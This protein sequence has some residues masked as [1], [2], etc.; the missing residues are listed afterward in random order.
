MSKESLNAVVTQRIEMS[1]ELV[2]FRVAPDG[3]ELP[4]FEAGQFAVLGL[5]GKS[6]R[7]IW[8]DPEEKPPEP[9]RLI[10]RAYSLASSSASSEYLEFYIMIVRSG[11]LTPRL[12]SLEQRDR[13]WLG[14]KIAGMFT[15]ED[16]PEDKN[17]VLISTGTGLAPY[18]SM[19]RSHL[20]CGSQ[21]RF[22]VLHGA[23][24]SW[25]LG[26]RAELSTMHRLC[27][28]FDYFP[29][30][31]R[32]D[33][34]PVP[35]QGATGYVQDLWTGGVLEEAWNSRPTRADAHVFLCGNPRM[36]EQMVTQ[37]KTE[38]FREHTRKEAGEIHVERYW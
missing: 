15:L 13:V 4:L 9:E 12:F 31:S 16:V 27:D 36:C 22:A 37:L 17:I 33:E 18:V 10:R 6:A 5:P 29:L 20:V 7:I 32:P 24:H 35:W 8:S 23:R 1:P 11:R 34:E 26:Y 2:L 3:W 14:Q 21:Q 28:N 19:L 38:G 25:D 30:V